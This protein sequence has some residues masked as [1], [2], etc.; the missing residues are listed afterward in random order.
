MKKSVDRAAFS[1]YFQP[2]WY[3]QH[4]VPCG[5]CSFPRAIY[6]RD[7][8]LGNLDAVLGPHTVHRVRTVESGAFTAGYKS[9]AAA[10][11]IDL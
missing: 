7:T 2:V 5:F 4:S 6:D 1:R 10:K 9:M 11:K 3:T 8:E